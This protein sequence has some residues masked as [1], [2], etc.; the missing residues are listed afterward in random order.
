MSEMILQRIKEKLYKLIELDENKQVFGA[1][2]EIYGHD[3]VLNPPVDIEKIRKFEKEIKEKLPSRYFL[4]LTKIC[5]GKAGPDYGLYPFEEAIDT[6]I[7][8]YNKFNYNNYVSD[9]KK[10]FSSFPITTKQVEKYIKDEIEYENYT[11][12]DFTVNKLSGILLLSDFIQ[13]H[14]YI[15]VIKGEQKGKVWLYSDMGFLTPLYHK[16]TLKQYTFFDWYESWLDD[17]LNFITNQHIEKNEINY[18]ADEEIILDLFELNEFPKSIFE[19]RNLK[20]L[21]ITRNKHGHLPNELFEI[22]SLKMLDLSNNNLKKIPKNIKNLENLVYLNISNNYDLTEIPDELFDLVKLK[23]LNVSDTKLSSIQ[24]MIGK[25]INLK[26]LNLSNTNI[27]F[28]PEEF[29]NLKNLVEIEIKLESDLAYGKVFNMFSKLPKL[30]N[31]KIKMPETIPQSIGLMQNLR[32]LVILKNK[33]ISDKTEIVLPKEF[34]QLILDYLYIDAKNIVLP[35]DLGNL[36]YLK[37][38]CL[39]NNSIYS[40]KQRL[41]EFR[42]LKQLILPVNIDENEKKEIKEMLPNVFVY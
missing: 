19:N 33:K 30:K 17:S 22:K 37:T 34:N 39:N 6:A 3:Y 5:N 4:F 16:D 9:Y 29:E 32:R 21:Q 38:L 2:G 36:I 14:S 20:K 40:F 23:E 10:C 8:Y 26:Y 35:K 27:N 25:L 41:K 24:K 12:D 42:Y 28:L 31:L 7:Y 15:L 18:G 1:N 11:I 13:G